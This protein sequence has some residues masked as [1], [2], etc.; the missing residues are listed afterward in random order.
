MARE[1]EKSVTLADTPGLRTLR[2]HQAIT[3]SLL[4]IAGL[5]NFLDRSSLSIANTTVREEMHLNGTEMGWLL[6]AFSL[7]YGF[8]QLPLIGLLDRAGT[9]SVLGGGLILWSVAQMLTGGGGNGSA[10]RPV[11]VL[12][13]L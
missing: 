3:L 13:Q 10:P 9:R 4:F 12:P 5:V 1:V 7:A 11:A 6:S 2:R 8:A